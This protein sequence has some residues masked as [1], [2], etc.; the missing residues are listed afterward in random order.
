MNLAL[1]I[2]RVPITELKPAPYNPRR[3]LKP[4]D[5]GFGQIL[6]SFARFGNCQ[7]IVWNQRTKHVVGGHQRLEVIKLLGEKEVDVSVVD[8]SLEEEKALNIALNKI[9]GEWDEGKLASVLEELSNIPDLGA[10]ITGFS[11]GETSALLD[12]FLPRPETSQPEVFNASGELARQDPPIT[13]IG[14]LIELGNHRLICGDCTDPD[15]VRRVMNGE[16]AVL[17]AT[18]PPYLVGYDGTNHPGADSG[19]KNKDWSGTYG[20]SWDDADANPALYERFLRT[21]VAEALRDNAAWYIWHASR[22]QAMLEAAM[23]QAGAFV[24]AQIIWVKNRPVLTRT[25]YAWRH[26]P[27]LFGWKV[28]CKPPKVDTDVLSTVWELDTIPNGDERP[29]HPTPKPLEVFEIPMRQ[30]TARGDV[31]FEPFCGS[32]TQIIAAERLDR[33]CF[34]VEI[35]PVYCDVIVRRYIALAGENAVSPEIAARYR[36]GGPA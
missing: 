30:H 4:G 25:W 24:H 36:R 17:F 10:E 22:N 1:T 18:D 12:E 33:R 20:T 35:S 14:D 2:R 5:P 21:A 7:T 32:G 11:A 27:C 19:T 16:R 31:C 26:E 6:T 8:L 13:K 29:D 28:G 3:A 34:A 15:V 9:T 23:K